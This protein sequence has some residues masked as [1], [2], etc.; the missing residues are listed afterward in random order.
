MVN[1]HVNENTKIYE[2]KVAELTKVCI[3]NSVAEY[4]KT[5]EVMGIYAII[6]YSLGQILA[7]KIGDIISEEGYAPVYMLCNDTQCGKNHWYVAEE[8]GVVEV[9][10]V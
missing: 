6:S 10:E 3:E 5:N 1:K 7:V 8:T 2:V 4:V 9:A